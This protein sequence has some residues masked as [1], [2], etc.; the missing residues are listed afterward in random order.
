VQ[1]LVECAHAAPWELGRFE[2]TYVPAVSQLLR[3]A[4]EL[5]AMLAVDAA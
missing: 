2:R 5:G 1:T 3:H 4:P